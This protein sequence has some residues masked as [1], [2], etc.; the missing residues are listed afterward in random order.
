[1]TQTSPALRAAIV[2]EF[3]GEAIPVSEIAFTHSIPARIVG[4]ILEEEQKSK[5]RTSFST[6]FKRRVA[7]FAHRNQTA[8]IANIARHFYLKDE[9]IIRN[10]VVEFPA[11]PRM[12]PQHS[13]LEPGNE[14]KTKYEALERKYNALLN[15]VAGEVS[16]MSAII[17]AQ[18]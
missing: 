8:T 17:Q 11:T 2:E 6:K 15:T 13:L 12:D 16:R 3:F 7:E 18:E 9:R 14:W 5:H 1:M 4:E 10:W